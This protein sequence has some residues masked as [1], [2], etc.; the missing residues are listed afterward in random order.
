MYHSLQC[1]DSVAT[2]TMNQ[3]RYFNFTEQK[4]EELPI[5]L[6]RDNGGTRQILYYDRGGA[7]SIAGLAIGVTSGGVKTYMVS[8][9]L[10][11]GS[12][13]KIKLG[14][15]SEISL[16]MARSRA[17]NVLAKLSDGVDPNQQEK[18]KKGQQITLREMLEVYISNKDLKQRT[19]KDYRAALRE[20]WSDYLDRPIGDITESIVQ[21]RNTSRGKSSKARTANAMRVLRAVFNYAAAEYK[22]EG[23]Y[24]DNPVTTLSERRTWH[25][26]ARRKTF[27][28]RE[29]LQS[30]WYA[31]QELEF[32][33]RRY[34]TFLLLTGVRASEAMNLRW[35]D[36]NFR[37]KTFHIR[38]PKN[39][40]ADVVLP[41]SD[42]LVSV[43]KPKKSKGL[44][45][46]G[47]TEDKIRRYREKIDAQCGVK[48]TSHDLR[49]T[50]LT[51]GDGLGIGMLTVKRLA[52]HKTQESDVTSG[53]IIST[54]NR[55]RNASNA[56]SEFVLEEVEA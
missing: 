38:D 37:S 12:P 22:K 1:S 41:L 9:R 3:E 2:R 30:W 23:L 29:D 16:K 17:K 26:V 15:H 13:R 11:S 43:M 24:K 34:F 35:E 20:T 56:I 6:A 50:F 47:I 55:L 32:M 28:N 19:I 7:K 54:T 45:F 31:V 5:P 51:I 10:K 36:L 18:E 49:R 33:P 42:H 39:R 48:F 4:L 25:K 44:V 8:K 14:R 27:I 52:N 21:D 46:S 40:E 53:Y